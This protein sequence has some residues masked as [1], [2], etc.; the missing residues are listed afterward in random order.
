MDCWILS[1]AELEICCLI[2]VWAIVVAVQ[3][4]SAG[5]I[6][7]FTVCIVQ[8]RPPPSAVTIQE[9]WIDQRWNGYQHS[10][11]I[12]CAGNTPNTLILANGGELEI[13]C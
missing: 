13:E 4:P 9:N 1:Q 2:E 6:A 7:I 10:A 11:R 12:Q 3:Q 5:C 8:H